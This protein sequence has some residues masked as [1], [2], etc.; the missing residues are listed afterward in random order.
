M[1]CVLLRGRLGR[2]VGVIVGLVAS[3]GV[4]HAQP[5]QSPWPM[6]G[7]NTLRTSRSP[8]TGPVDGE[9]QVLWQVSLGSN[10]FSPPSL[11][12]DGTIYVPCKD[13]SLV[14]VSPSGTVKWRHA[15]GGEYAS[16][17]AVAADGSIYFGASATLYAL[18]PDGTRQWDIYMGSSGYTPW[19]YAP[20]IGPDGTIYMGSR[21]G[22]YSINPNGSERWGRS[23]VDGPP[24]LLDD[25]STIVKVGS[26]VWRYGPN[27]DLEWSTAMPTSTKTPVM[28]PDGTIYCGQYDGRL[29]ALDADTGRI[30]RVTDLP[31]RGSMGTSI[32]VT[33]DIYIA[34]DDS[35]EKVNSDGVWQWSVRGVGFRPGA[36][37]IDG[38][39]N[40]FSSEGLDGNTLRAFSPEGDIIWEFD[41]G[42]GGQR[43]R[44]PILGAD[45]LLYV[46]SYPGNGEEGYLYAIVPEPATLSLL[47]LGGLVGLRRRRRQID[48]I[49]QGDCWMP[50]DRPGP[51]L[52]EPAGFLVFF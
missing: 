14:A 15:T 12:A 45:N 36:P 37:L 10:T 50:C 20:A 16:S 44:Q 25:G 28:A 6:G 5:A 47:A 41:V 43:V 23:G 42:D 13:G 40:I 11:G 24:V 26:G 33:G 7:Q 22:L 17:P 2:V 49:R 35:L 18:N 19:A 30:V 27:G 9:I 3:G 21:G 4:L 52:D 39:G 31:V 8:L 51:A 34:T 46:T 32:D 1:S 38:N 48:T 29:Y